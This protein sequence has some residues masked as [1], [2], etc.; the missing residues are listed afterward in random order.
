MYAPT[1]VPAESIIDLITTKINAAMIVGYLIVAAIA[2][3]V[4]IVM[5]VKNHTLGG[6]LKALVIAALIAW[7]GVSGVNFFKA[8]IGGEFA[9]GITYLHQDQT[10]QDGPV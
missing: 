9:A 6:V 10:V 1:S 5:V 8:R 4:F 2:L 3:G 7:G